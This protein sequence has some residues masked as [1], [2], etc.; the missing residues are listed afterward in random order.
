M[1]EWLA[2]TPMMSIEQIDPNDPQNRHLLEVLNSHK[3]TGS[4]DLQLDPM[5]HSLFLGESNLQRKKSIR[6]QPE[7]RVLR[8]GGS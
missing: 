8:G 4:D 7:S 1:C 2:L 6:I 3:D 5:H